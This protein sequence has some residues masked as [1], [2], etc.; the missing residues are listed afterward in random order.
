MIYLAAW[1][2]GSIAT[3]LWDADPTGTRRDKV[4]SATIW[5]LWLPLVAVALTALV[6]GMAVRAGR[7]AIARARGTRLC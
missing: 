5:P 4:I 6:A 1:A 7:D 2:V 3:Y